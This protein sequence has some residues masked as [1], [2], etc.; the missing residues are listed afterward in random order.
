[1]DAAPHLPCFAPLTSDIKEKITQLLK[2]N[3]LF[4]WNMIEIV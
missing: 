1:M 3:G 2:K 4:I